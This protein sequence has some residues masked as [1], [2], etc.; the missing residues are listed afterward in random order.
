MY[1][2]LAVLAAFAFVYSVVASR[3]ERTAINGPVVFL[4]FGT[5][6]SVEGHG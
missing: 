4:A 5:P 3:L 2:T 1:G 6:R